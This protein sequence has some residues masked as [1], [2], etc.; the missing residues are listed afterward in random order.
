MKIVEFIHPFLDARH[1]I[2][3][4]SPFKSLLIALKVRG[5]SEELITYIFSM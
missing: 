3:F 2:P 5:L 4:G 1:F